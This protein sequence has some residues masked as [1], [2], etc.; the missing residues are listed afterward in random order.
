[1]DAERPELAE[2]LA[3]PPE[4]DV[5]GKLSELVERDLEEENWLDTIMWCGRLGRPVSFP[6]E[7]APQSVRDKVSALAG[8]GTW[9]VTWEQQDDA[10]WLMIVT[11]RLTPDE[12][13]RLDGGT[14]WREMFGG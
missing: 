5:L 3:G 10:G 13:A 9:T 2:L 8:R 1:M 4:A 12:R 14:N 11:D 6:A 7:L